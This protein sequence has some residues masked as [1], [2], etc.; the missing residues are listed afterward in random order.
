[1]LE[2][3]VTGG[4]TGADQAG[5]RAAKSA[6]IATG[7][8]V[9]MGCWTEDGERPGFVDD[10]G[11]VPVEGGD[12][13]ESIRLRTWL[14]ALES[15]ATIWFGD[16]KSPGGKATRH[17]CNRLRKPFLVIA[18]PGL[19]AAEES[20]RVIREAGYRVLNVAGNRESSVP[21]IGAW[22]EA[23]LVEVFRLLKAEGD[24]PG[25]TLALV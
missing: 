14:N 10:Y 25:S 13:D 9:P 20:A 16:H 21:G 24:L 23:H 17:D 22:V 11:A 4:Q 7:G 6:G 12:L 1:M 18:R 3:V 19:V 5:W 2:R 8:F 15:D